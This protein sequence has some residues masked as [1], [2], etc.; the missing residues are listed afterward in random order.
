MTGGGGSTGTGTTTSAAGTSSGSIALPDAGAC[1]ADPP[2]FDGEDCAFSP[3]VLCPYPSACD[4][5]GCVARCIAGKAVIDCASCGLPEPACPPAPPAHGAPC[6]TASPEGTKCTWDL[7]TDQTFVWATCTG[8]AWDVHY[9]ACEPAGCYQLGNGPDPVQCPSD[10][11]CIQAPACGVGALG[12]CAPNACAHEPF[13]CACAGML[14]G[15]YLTCV[16]VVGGVVTCADAP[17]P[18]DGRVLL[19]GGQGLPGPPALGTSVVF[20]AEEDSAMMPLHRVAK[21][22]GAVSTI[23]TGNGFSLASDDAA[24]F[25]ADET[26]ATLSVLPDGSASPTW[27][28]TE[29]VKPAWVFLDDARV[30]WWNGGKEL[31][32][33]P[34]AGGPTQSLWADFP[35]GFGPAASD[36]VTI[37]FAAVGAPEIRAMPA[38]GGAATVLATIPGYVA[39]LALDG[40]DLYF[41]AGG[42]NIGGPPTGLVARMPKAGGAVEMLA[43]AETCP[44]SIA[45]RDGVVYWSSDDDMASGGG[46]IRMV[47]A[48][49]GVPQTLVENT[50]RVAGIAV[51]ATRVYW[52]A[53]MRAPCGG[54]WSAPR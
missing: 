10:A 35:N 49:G 15:P 48:A 40:A 5:H 44:Q 29:L 18:Q 28:A 52:S 53:H 50:G 8:T 36:G 23:A 27:I 54:V 2:A 38:T 20:W 33:V 46:V 17:P 9:S 13:S 41:T 1:P 11:L 51:D 4:P 32:A 39:A 37:F 42:C 6:D 25:F 43:S 34:R 14:C 26:G 31:D 22:G 3:T 19:A 45:V 47:P 16:S 30:Y 24:L 7:C 21:G 12:A